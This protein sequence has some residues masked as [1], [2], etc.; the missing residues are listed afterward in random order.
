VEFCSTPNLLASIGFSSARTF[1]VRWPT[2][3]GQD[4]YFSRLCC[5]SMVGR[6][7]HAPTFQFFCFCVC[8]LQLFSPIS[9]GADLNLWKS[10]VARKVL[11]EGACF[12]RAVSGSRFLP[13]SALWVSVCVCFCLC[14]CLL[15]IPAFNHSLSLGNCF[16]PG[17]PGFVG[18]DSSCL[19]T[20]TAFGLCFS[21][22]GVKFVSDALLVMF[23]SYL[24]CIPLGS[25]SNGLKWKK[26]ALC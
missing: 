13:V 6:D 3:S 1:Q 7:P 17:F 20:P 2:S 10:Y 18:R 22:L 12:T 21:S 25:C 14:L 24:V 11:G 26:T 8:G 16:K 5:S 19:F 9:E 15:C 4:G 23:V